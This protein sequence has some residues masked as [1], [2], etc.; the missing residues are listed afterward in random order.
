MTTIDKNDTA[1][2]SFTLFE[3]IYLE[4]ETYLVIKPFQ[5]I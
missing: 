5:N 2:H 1:S 4:N 3:T